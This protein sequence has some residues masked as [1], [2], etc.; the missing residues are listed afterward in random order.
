LE[1]DQLRCFRR[2]QPLHAL[3]AS[4]ERHHGEVKVGY[5]AGLSITRR[6]GHPATQTTQPHHLTGR[7][8]P[9]GLLHV[10][11]QSGRLVTVQYLPNLQ[12]QLT[13]QQRSGALASGSLVPA[14]GCHQRGS[15]PLLHFVVD[16]MYGQFECVPRLRCRFAS[17]RRLLGSLGARSLL[18]MRLAVHG[19]VRDAGACP[20]S[21]LVSAQQ[22]TPFIL[23][24]KESDSQ[25]TNTDS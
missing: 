5:A 1:V 12:H 8:C 23:Q 11:Q 17:L 9:L 18:L 14:L 3:R 7:L 13:L 25:Q 15:E 24:T 21:S 20:W 22:S 2:V 16:R 19:V 4:D 10:P 6:E